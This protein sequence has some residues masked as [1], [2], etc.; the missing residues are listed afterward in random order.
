MAS[1]VESHLPVRSVLLDWNGSPLRM[2]DIE[3]VDLAVLHL[4]GRG[5]F[6]A[7]FDVVVTIDI[8]ICRDELLGVVMDRLCHCGWR[9]NQNGQ[10][11]RDGESK[12]KVSRAIHFR[13][14]L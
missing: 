3:S 6:A 9:I 11:D 12:E 13:F 7:V 2:A 10:T 8:A 1:R 14:Y 4:H 5:E